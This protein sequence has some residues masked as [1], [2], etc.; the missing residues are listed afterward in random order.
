MDRF[1]TF[2][3]AVCLFALAS[4]LYVVVKPPLGGASGVLVGICSLFI[5]GSAVGFLFK[6]L[7]LEKKS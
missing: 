1:F 4:Y 5:A 3:F 7:G 6:A 2:V